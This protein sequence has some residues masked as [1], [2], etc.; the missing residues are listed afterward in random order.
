MRPAERLFEPCLRVVQPA[1]L[2]SDP[3]Q[4]IDSPHCARLIRHGAEPTQCR[5]GKPGGAL[6]GAESRRCECR[7]I[8][9]LRGM[10]GR[11][12]FAAVVE[13]PER[14][15]KSSRPREFAQQ[16]E[17]ATT[18]VGRESF[19]FHAAAAMPTERRNASSTS[20][21]HHCGV[22]RMAHNASSWD[23]AGR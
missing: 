13:G 12:S 20:G 18:P 11:S 9:G 10:C 19:G 7:E 14:L 1:L 4:E 21:L 23:K 3:A 6:V 2:E 22:S 15:A 16:F 5:F 8:L 17:I